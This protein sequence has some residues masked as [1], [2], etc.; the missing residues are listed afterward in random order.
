VATALTAAISQ[1]IAD[2]HDACGAAARPMTGAASSAAA[3]S[4]SG[5]AACIINPEANASALS[6]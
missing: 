2:G 4:S 6:R 3:T 1:V 5:H